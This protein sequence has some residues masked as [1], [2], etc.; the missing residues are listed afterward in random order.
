MLSITDALSLGR[1][2]KMWDLYGFIFSGFLGGLLYILCWSKTAKELKDYKNIK[3]LGIGAIIGYIY[4]FL[5]S[6]YNFPNSIMSLI[7]GYMGVDFIES[8]V[9]RFAPF[10]KKP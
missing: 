2:G 8:L 1:G 4:F 9:E 7:A 6:D 10:F 3:R 5:H